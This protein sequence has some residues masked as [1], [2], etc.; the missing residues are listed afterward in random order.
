MSGRPTHPTQLTDVLSYY[1]G[2]SP[3]DHALWKTIEWRLF[4]EYDYPGPVLDLGCGDGIFAELVFDEPLC[5]GIDIRHGRVRQAHDAGVY[6]LSITGDAT[7]MPYADA[8]FG[9]I[10]SGCA[11]EHVPPMPRMLAEIRRVLKPGGCLITTV[12]SG[13]FSEYLWVPGV[14]RRWG[15]DRAATQYGKLIRRLLT[16]FHMYHPAT[17]QRLLAEAGLELVEARHFLSREATGLF[18]R[19]LIAGNLAQPLVWLL[20]GT[21]LHRRYVGWLTSKL[22]PYVSGDA[23]SGGALLLVARKPG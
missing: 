15:L 6:R 17:W 9:T 14:L 20:R 18:D 7:A 23:G 22:L 5:T 11:M 8:Q 3:P 13:Y 2:H 21:P 1:A 16:I 12:P 4:R 10:F 19:L